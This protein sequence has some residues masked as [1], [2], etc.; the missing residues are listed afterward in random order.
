M[1]KISRTGAVNRAVDGPYRRVG[2]VIIASLLVV[3]L[4]FGINVVAHGF[5]FKERRLAEALIS[6]LQQ[7]HV[8][9]SVKL[10]YQSQA[11]ALTVEGDM[12]YVGGS[13]LGLDSTVTLGEGQEGAVEIPVQLRA[14]LEDPAELFIKASSLEDV[15]KP[16]G[17]AIPAINA[18]I[19]SIAQKANDKWLR[20][21][22]E[23][24]DTGCLPAVMK[25]LQEDDSASKELS[26]AYMSNRFIDVLSVEKKGEATQVYDIEFDSKALAAFTDKMYQ[27]KFIGSI[28]ECEEVVESVRAGAQQSP[29]L[30][31]QPQADASKSLVSV[32]V[33]DGKVVAIDSTQ[34]EQS[35]VASIA[36]LLDFDKNEVA[37]PQENVIE[38]DR[39][40]HEVKSIAEF[41]V[42]Q[43]GSQQSG[44]AGSALQPRQ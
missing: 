30:S 2:I 7:P 1:G 32:T 31:Q 16:L 43:Q 44:A 33:K 9:G 6:T 21:G 3:A 4:L 12:K 5:G 15:A 39:I 28:D 14:S 24:G 10:S 22:L 18:D 37:M 29:Q 38:S 26:R 19:L 35:S 36:I 34:T 20:Y 42:E 17:E 40:Q 25:K 23:G 11:S 41:I 27:T 8:N 13:A